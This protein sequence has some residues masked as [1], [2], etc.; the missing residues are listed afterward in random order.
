MHNICKDWSVVCVCLSFILSANA[1]A[2]IDITPEQAGILVET[3]DSLVVVDVREEATE[4]C[5]AVGHIAGAL[6]YPWISGVLQERFAELPEDQAILVICKSGV[7][8]NI[9]AEFL[10]DQGFILVFDMLGG[11]LA[12]EGDTV[13]C[14][15]IDQDGVY[16]E[17]DTC[18]CDAD[19]NQVD[20]DGD[21]LGDLCDEDTPGLTFAH[22][23]ITVDQAQTLIDS[24]LPILILDVRDDFEYCDEV[25][26]I[27]GALYYSMRQGVLQARLN[28]IPKDKIL[29]VHCKSGGRSKIV[30]NYL[31]SEGYAHVFN[32]LGGMDSWTGETVRCIDIDDDGVY[33]D[34]DRCPCDADSNQVDT[35]GDGIGDVCDEDTLG[36]AF[37]HTDI[38]PQ[39]AQDLIDSG[40]PIMIL[41]VR[42]LSE[43]CDVVG[44]IPGALNYPYS[45]GVLEANLAEIPK[46]QILLVLCKAGGRSHQAAMILDE[47]GYP[48]VLDMLGGMG[49]WTGETIP[50]TD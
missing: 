41:D 14:V 50:C 36:Q 33:D 15:D 34:V 30:A 4:Y 25:G 22:T 42:E 39:Q 24:G 32:M 35:D 13:R 10:D 26:H 37:T 48:H 38:T 18:P 43:Y 2:H 5:D 20:T 21:G 49:A 23:D 3:F 8:S 47:Q 28:E 19:P 17:F 9:A 7:R 44:H 6:N 16:D 40:L 31:D 27:P 46:D 12:W 29:L 45:S 1:L 11:M